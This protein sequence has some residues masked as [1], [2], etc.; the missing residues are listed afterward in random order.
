MFILEALEHYAK[1]DR[2]AIR[3]HDEQ[4]RFAAL[5]RMADAFAAYLCRALPDD[6]R[7]IMIYGHKQ[8]VIPACMFGALKAGHGYIPVDTTYPAD[9]AA[10]ILYD[11]QPSVLVDL[12]A[13]GLSAEHTLSAETLTQILSQPAA[14]APR[15]GWLRTEQTA[16]LLFTS[17]STGTPKGVQITAGN[18]AAFG[19]GVKP[20]FDEMREGGAFLNEISYSFDVSVC[21][22]YEA[23]GRGM[24]LWTADLQTL[25]NPKA[26]F[27]LLKE[28]D[29]TDW[30][31][32]P[33]LA[34]LCVQS[35]SF[36][37]D[38]M[39]NLRQFL[40]CGEVLTKKLCGEM[41]E[42]FPGVP[43]V[44]AYGPTETTVLVTGAEMTEKM[45]ESSEP[46][47][48][49][50][51]FSNCEAG[52]CDEAGNALPD[53]E[54]GELR[55]YGKTVS[56]GYL[57]RPELN[58]RVFFENETGLRGYRTGDLCKK[59]D[60]CIYY[61][62]RLDNQIKLNGFRVELEDVENNLV[63]VRNVA[64]AAVLPEMQ[65]GKVVSLTA[66]VLLEKPDGEGS[67]QRARRIKKELS[68]LVPSYMVP[69]KIV[70]VESF[71]LNTNG[72]IDKKRLREQSAT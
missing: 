49:G 44:N 53:G 50:F 11:A 71:P 52:I 48:I 29:L 65:N 9:R 41:F 8:S 21:A 10:Q 54:A 57:G 15:S 68:A 24:T 28:A 59:T 1:T 66:Y 13:S 2:I 23:L 69:R 43:V 26:L 6:G 40:F 17:G 63:K 47:P 45:L 16:Y 36:R 5:D 32:T 60:G 39:P 67:L 22:L 51:A 14:P 46:L 38:L 55:I 72:K 37:K 35:E 42:R 64:R 3:Y 62:G 70:A 4:V 7:P 34:E 30:V 19:E 33:S 18:L 25:S 20:W 27:A 58:A 12:C 61:L 56:P 31:S